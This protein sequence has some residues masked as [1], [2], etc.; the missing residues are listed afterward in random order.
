MSAS[1]FNNSDIIYGKPMKDKKG[2]TKIKITSKAINGDL[3]VSSPFLMTWGCEDFQG[4]EKFTISLMLPTSD[5][6]TTDTDNFLIK[7]Q[8]IEKNI[9]DHVIKNAESFFGESKSTEVIKHMRKPILITKNKNYPPT[10]RP[11]IDTYDGKWKV[12]VFDDQKNKLFPSNLIDTPQKL[13]PK[14]SNVAAL[15]RISH[16][17]IGPKQWKVVVK[18]IQ[19]IVRTP[20]LQHTPKVSKCQ[21][22]LSDEEK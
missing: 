20:N 7:M 6:S 14:L 12:E 10:L 15:L 19:C 18:L 11:H 17:W 3:D 22:L 1:T 16:I 8:N 13:I 4:D 5:Y 2:N 21:I 9:L